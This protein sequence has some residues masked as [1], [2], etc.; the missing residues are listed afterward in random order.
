MIVGVFM[1][2]EVRL[3]GFSFL[4]DVGVLLRFV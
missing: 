4:S 2:V 3:L 1:C